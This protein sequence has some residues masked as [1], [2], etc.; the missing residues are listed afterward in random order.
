MVVERIKANFTNHAPSASLG[1]GLLTLVAIAAVV[2]PIMTLVGRYSGALQQ[3]MKSPVG[4]KLGQNWMWVAGGGAFTLLLGSGFALY[5]F[6]KPKD[7]G[8][9]TPLQDPSAQAAGAGSLA[10]GQPVP[11]PTTSSGSATQLAP[12]SPPLAEPT[13]QPSLPHSSSSSSSTQSTQS[14]PLSSSAPASQ[15]TREDLAWGKYNDGNGDFYYWNSITSISRWEP[16]A[17]WPFGKT[18]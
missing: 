2:L 15:F 3:F 4:P 13:P 7:E 17:G 18:E 6:R 16:P 5:S 12:L 9:G 11:Q 8:D 10:A 1:A 14:P